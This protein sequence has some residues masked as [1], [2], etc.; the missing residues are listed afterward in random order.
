MI[1]YTLKIVE[2][3]RETEDACTICFKQ[4]ALRKIQYVSGQYITLIITINNRK[5][6]RPYSLSSSPGIDSTLNITVKR[7][8]HGIVSN[9]LMD[10]IKEG[11]LLEVME[12][13]GD[14]VYKT[15]IHYNNE[16]FLWGAGSGITPLMSILKTALH[17]NVQRIILSYC[18]KSLEKTIFYGQLV[19]FKKQYVNQFSLRL[20]CTEEEKLDAKYGRINADDVAKVFED[21][22]D[23]KK[24]IHYICGPIGLKETV[25]NELLNQGL[26]RDQIFSEDFEH[27]INENELKEIQS[28]FIEIIKGNDRFKI[29][30]VRGKSILEAGLDRQIDLPYSCQTGSCTLCKAK[31]IS[32]E[33]KKISTEASEHKLEDNERLLCCSY[34]LTDNIIFEID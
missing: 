16:L 1:T 22:K 6:K 18:N 31:L 20:F 15:D 24:T 28:R 8:L 25:K 14:F 30:V 12:P 21:I 4:P 7:L 3:L 13:I 29:E 5:Y 34:P 9:H 19:Q 10:V 11:D 26:T 23:K 32:G 2:I 33:V 17:A 27:I